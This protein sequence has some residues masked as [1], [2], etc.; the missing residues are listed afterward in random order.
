MADKTADVIEV[1]GAVV[2]G[3]PTDLA[4]MTTSIESSFAGLFDADERPN[5]DTSGELAHLEH[6][7]EVH[8]VL[9]EVATALESYEYNGT[10]EERVSN[11][12]FLA[13]VRKGKTTM[14]KNINAFK[15]EY[16]AD[17]DDAASMLENDFADIEA[18]A[19]QR[20]DESDNRFREE[21]RAALNAELEDALLMDER[22]EGL[23][24]DQFIDKTWF[25]RTVSVNK[26]KGELSERLDEFKKLLEMN[27]MPEYS[28]LEQV[29]MLS[30]HSWNIINAVSAY[31]DAMR[32]RADAE[33]I[34]KQREQERAAKEQERA[35]RTVVRLAIR[36][37]QLDAAFDALDEA[38]IEYVR[39]S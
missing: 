9:R 5:I 2:D 31:Q 17:V 3:T 25:N 7:D 30:L 33:A 37:D 13:A 28:A 27:L 34:A 21:R 4:V 20:Q 19:K 10:E 39:M 16:F 8:A 32:E 35:A 26:A 36:N 38:G 18:I 23:G 6:A 11:R 22:L 29:N 1:E 14:K 15:R 24:L 12:K